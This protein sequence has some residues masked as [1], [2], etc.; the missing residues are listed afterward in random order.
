MQIVCLALGSILLILFIVQSIKGKKYNNM[1]ENLDSAEFPLKSIYVVGFSWNERKLLSLKGKA[2]K[3]LL[4]NAK[5]LYESKYAEYYA[6]VVWSQVLS[7]TH[8]CL[9]V[10][11]LL[12][13]ALDSFFMLFIGLAIAAVFD[14]YF[15]N[16][17]NDL[18]KTRGDACVEELPEIVS[19][20]ALLI[21]A[22]MMLRD[23][24]KTIADSKDGPIYALMKQSCTDMDNGTSE[25]DAIHKFGRLSNS[26]EVRKFTSA[27]CQSI[28]RGGAELNDFL[29][30]QAV[31]IWTLKKQVMLQKGEAA[32]S[33]L[34]APT[35][36]LFVGIIIAVLAGALGMLI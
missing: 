35:A 9:I 24:W 32:S 4:N 23:A 5:L 12:A 18:L 14:F 21:N 25:V 6:T 30:R 16:R 8:L 29:A 17:M 22:G 33:K 34:L 20:M 27:L 19:T 11:L 28:E 36:M 31:E 7:F 2:R 1:I 3:K 10:G 13:G 15:I 26:Q